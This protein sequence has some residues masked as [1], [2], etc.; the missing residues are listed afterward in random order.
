MIIA[1]AE[2]LLISALVNSEDA[3]GAVNFG[4]TPDHFRGYKDEYN[5]LLNYV[6]RYDDQPSK[7]I[8]LSE[9]RSFPMDQHYDIRSA[10]DQVFKA[11]AKHRITEATAESFDLL[12]VGNVQGAYERLVAA[13]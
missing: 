6:E 5:W 2:S 13:K 7:A 9:F 8:F 3:R 4:I 11:W 10:V 1:S 12:S